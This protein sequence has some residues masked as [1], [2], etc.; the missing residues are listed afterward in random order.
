MLHQLSA[1]SGHGRCDLGYVAA[2][3]IQQ[4]LAEWILQKPAHV[5][6]LTHGADNTLGQKFF[7]QGLDIELDGD[8]T[9]RNGRARGAVVRQLDLVEGKV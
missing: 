6:A 5:V 3:A 8:M 1:A 7:V 4:L 9:L 2:D